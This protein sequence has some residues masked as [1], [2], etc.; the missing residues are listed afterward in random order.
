MSG[1]IHKPGKQPWYYAARDGS[2]LTTADLWD[3]WRNP[4]TGEPLLSCTMLKKDKNKN[5]VYR[6]QMI[7]RRVKEWTGAQGV[8]GYLKYLAQENE[9]LFVPMVKMIMDQ[10]KDHKGVEGLQLP[11]LEDLRKEWIRRGLRAVDFDKMK[12]VKGIEAKQRAKLIEH[13]PREPMRVRN[14]SKKRQEREAASTTEPESEQWWEDE[15]EEEG[16]A[17]D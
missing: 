4:E 14:G 6:P 8:L 7:R 12:V 16:E 11:T 17:E 5:P 3:S 2:A 13:D 10:Q 1:R 9:A 15:P